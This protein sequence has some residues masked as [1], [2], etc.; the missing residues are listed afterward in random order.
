MWR[1]MEE[2]PP[3]TFRHCQMM[4]RPRHQ[5]GD[6]TV[7]VEQA[8]RELKSLLGGGDGWAGGDGG[9]PPPAGLL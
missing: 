7:R 2:N 5:G 9:T 8:G 3:A 4:T 1:F 6:G